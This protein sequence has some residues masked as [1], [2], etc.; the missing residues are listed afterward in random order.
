MTA[1]WLGSNI[2]RVRGRSLMDSQHQ[3][4]TVIAMVL[5]DPQLLSPPCTSWTLDRLTAWLPGSAA[6]PYSA[7]ASITSPAH[8]RTPRAPVRQRPYA[9]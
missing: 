6:S 7:A 5:T 9:V 3:V 1:D 4:A 8:S 2:T